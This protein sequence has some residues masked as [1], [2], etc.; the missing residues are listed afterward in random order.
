[1]V[2]GGI[3]ATLYPEEALRLGNAHSVV[4][5]DGD[6]VWA[7]ALQACLNG[8]PASVYE[9]GKDRIRSFLGNPLGSASQ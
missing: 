7:E 8:G 3:H 1:M 9:G 4:R 5:G 6:V 2:F